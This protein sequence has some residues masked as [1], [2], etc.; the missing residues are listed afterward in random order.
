MARA[1]KSA[2][3]GNAYNQSQLKTISHETI[4]LR[5]LA[6]KN[7]GRIVPS[8]AAAIFTRGAIPNRVDIDQRTEIVDSRNH[9]VTG[10]VMPCL[11]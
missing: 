6:N 11:S 7:G 1:L 2:P 10:R 4:Y 8:S 5:I 3:I 9:Q